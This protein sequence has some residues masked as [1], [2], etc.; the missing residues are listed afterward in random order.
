MS[1]TEPP[2]RRPAIPTQRGRKRHKR[3]ATPRPFGTHP[4]DH[5]FR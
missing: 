2:I 3:G 1:P 4:R 5:F